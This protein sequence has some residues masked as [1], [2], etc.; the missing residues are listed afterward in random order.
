MI[1]G[2]PE[3]LIRLRNLDEFEPFR[4]WLEEEKSQALKVLVSSQEDRR[5][6]AAQ[7]AYNQIERLQNLIN[8]ADA[9][10]DKRRG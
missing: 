7:G 5:M 3:V 2:L 6:Y 9:L 10:L 8:G 4:K 1:N